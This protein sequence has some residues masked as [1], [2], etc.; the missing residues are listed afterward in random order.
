MPQANF[1]MG[2]FSD[3]EAGRLN[4]YENT[5]IYIMLKTGYTYYQVLPSSACLAVIFGNDWLAA[6]PALF[7]Q[8][9]AAYSGKA[10]IF[11]V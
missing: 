6:A 11:Y 10:G 3:S 5:T 2:G 9:M 4:G 8:S 1:K 7:A